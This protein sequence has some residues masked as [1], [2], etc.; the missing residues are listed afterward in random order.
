MEPK[1]T[2]DWSPEQ[3][4]FML[5]LAMPKRA[6]SFKTQ[7]RFAAHIGVH[8]STLSDWKRVDG[9]MAE[10]KAISVSLVDHDVPDIIHKM[11]SQAKGGS[12]IHQQMILEMAGVY[13]PKMKH[14]H[15]GPDD[16][17]ISVAIHDWKAQAQQQLDQVAN[18]EDDGGDIEAE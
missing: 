7:Q 14:E 11:V 13:A 12:F 8:E 9:F 15:T 1:T 17:P 3:A 18:L 5:W 2:K 4:E 10:V 6:R 16:G